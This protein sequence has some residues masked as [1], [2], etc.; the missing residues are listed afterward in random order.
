VHLIF[1]LF[2]LVW[3]LDMRFPLGD[4]KRQTLDHK[5]A[6]SVALTGRPAG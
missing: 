5:V 1:F 6:G 3:I 4:K 2:G